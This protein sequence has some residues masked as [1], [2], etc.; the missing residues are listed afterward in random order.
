MDDQPPFGGV[1]GNVTSGRRI[2]REH[3]AARGEALDV[4]I[5][6][7]EFHLARERISQRRCGG[8][9]QLTSHIPAGMDRCCS[10]TPRACW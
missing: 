10:P 7:L 5:A 8:L 4:T 3:D 6:C 9:C 2:L 1:A